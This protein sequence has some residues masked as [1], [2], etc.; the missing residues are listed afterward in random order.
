MYDSI[1][2]TRNT[3]SLGIQQPGVP[4]QTPITTGP[5]APAPITG[6]LRPPSPPITP[7]E[8]AGDLTVS[9]EQMALPAFIQAVYGGILQL[10]YSVD[11][12]VNARTDLI[13]F[14]TPKPISAAH[15]KELATQL[16]KSYGVAV[17]DF[18]GVLRIVPSTSIGSTLP[19]VRRGRA[20]P[21]VPQQLR[22]VFHYIETESVRSTNL[23]AP[24]KNILGDKV[25]VEADNFGGLM[26]S[27]Q[28]DDVQVALEL[29][30][31]FD[32]PGL[33]GQN[34][35]RIVPRYWGADE[36]A[37]R[38]S[39]VLKAE[40]YN[41]GTQSGPDPVT[42]VPLP[43]IN[44]VIVFA[45]SPQV[46]KHV[47]E[48]VRDL[49][50]LNAVQAG[51]AFFT[52]PVKH[53]DAQDLA[54]ALNDLVG[55]QSN[56]V[57]QNQP[58]TG[59]TPPSTPATTTQRQ[60]R[61]VVNGAT[62]SLIFQGGSQEDYRQWL[63]LLAE[64]D[65]P[66]KSALIDVLVAEV[67]LNDDSN[68]GFTWQLQQLG[69]GAQAV[70]LSG[71]TYNL[72]AGGSGLTVNALLGGNP[73]RQLA[74]TALAS[75]SDSR[76][77]SNPK[78][79][80]RNG[81]AANIS[82]G[83][84]VPTVSSQAVTT[85]TGIIGSNNTVVP[86]TIQYRNTGV[87]LRVRPVI[88][89][90]D[91]IDLEVSQ[92]VSSA[93]NTT[94][95]VTT[96]PTIRKRSVETKLSLRDGATIMLGGLI[97]ETNTDSDS[98]VPLLKDIP[99]LGSLFKT[100]TKSRQRTELVMLITPYVLNDTEDAEAATDAYQSTLGE[101]AESVR[102]R[103]RASREARQ[104]ATQRRA[105][106]R[107]AHEAGLPGAPLPPNETV[108]PDTGRPAAPA[109]PVPDVTPRMLAPESSLAPGE[110]MINFSDRPVEAVMPSSSQGN[111]LGPTGQGN[112]ASSNSPP[113]PA[114]GKP[115]PSSIGGVAVPQGSTVV[116]DPKLLEEILDTVRRR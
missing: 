67:A 15:L 81:E 108:T 32:Q 58:T 49:D 18:G 46:M 9:V 26:L 84:D 71:T 62:N 61:V 82:V 48:W 23:V 93:E 114:S 109:T 30:Q 19:L 24:L 13:T 33:R 29:V 94:T 2:D 40:G 98:G 105:G 59:G 39:E 6:N 11:A 56:N 100:A 96:S 37:R 51:S 8:A 36:F 76:V 103:V 3:G 57:Q 38:L 20:Q 22:P 77:I 107:A 72:N 65:R 54:K 66:V 70:R 106:V 53:A 89:A 78:I 101:W 104:A 102:Q 116:E 16:L 95:G 90:G 64:L 83:Q 74:I 60:R 10:N 35:S 63:A 41:V 7:S 55:S 12:S 4:K 50:Q 31:V 47:L 88:H 112:G 69:S 17:Q 27:G 110:Q 1:Q 68:L 113:A 28:P 99:G 80:T 97:S 25:K 75:N 43:P 92:E 42:L 14:R 21:T 44:S 111:A 86:Q 52:Y 73:L 79:V 34:S 5:K 45:S 87:L 85:N 115:A 91:R